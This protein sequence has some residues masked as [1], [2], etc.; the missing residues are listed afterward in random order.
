M[1]NG[2]PDLPL[3]AGVI[4]VDGAFGELGHVVLVLVD[5]RLEVQ[6]LAVERLGPTDADGPHDVR[7]VARRELRGQRVTSGF[8]RDRFERQLDVR[9]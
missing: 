7:S 3:A 6:P 4:Q 2:M 9:V 5:V 8:V 1:A